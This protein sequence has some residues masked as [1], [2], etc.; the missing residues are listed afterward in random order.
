MGQP[1]SNVTRMENSAAT[2]TAILLSTPVFFP[3]PIPTN[4]PS[5][6]S[7]VMTNTCRS[8]INMDSGF[9]SF[10]FS[11]SGLNQPV[12]PFRGEGLPIIHGRGHRGRAAGLQ[13]S[14]E[15]GE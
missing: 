3:T 1:K 12:E 4:I 10:Y 2:I 5:V 6:T 8:V 13:A 11:E 9:Y 7:K 14:G 15:R